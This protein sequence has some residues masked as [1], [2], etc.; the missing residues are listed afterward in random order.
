VTIAPVDINVPWVLPVA[1]ALWRSE[2][3]AE[4]ILPALQRIFHDNAEGVC[5]LICELG[6]AAS[7]LLPDVIRALAEEDWDLQW[8]A[9]DALRAIASTDQAVL[10]PLLD[11]L[12]HPSPIVRSASARALAAA[13]VAALG[14]LKV[15]LSDR[16]KND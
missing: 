10:S 9:A 3:R 13:A 4:S 5:D 7:P 1:S 12:A 14:A 6:P 15:L 8:A 2:G 11:A 16:L